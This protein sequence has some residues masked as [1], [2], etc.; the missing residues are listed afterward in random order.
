MYVRF[1]P[2]VWIVWLP[3]ANVGACPHPG[4]A[5][6]AP[7][8]LGAAAAPLSAVPTRPRTSSAAVATDPSQDLC[9]VIGSPPGRDG[10]RRRGP[11]LVGLAVAGPD[12]HLGSVRGRRAVHVEAQS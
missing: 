2:P 8:S 1:W 12:D 7:T 10:G 5:A 11:L 6:A 4:L 9:F 3:L